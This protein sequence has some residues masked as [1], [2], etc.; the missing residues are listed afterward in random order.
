MKRLLILITLLPLFLTGCNSAPQKST[1]N[2][3]TSNPVKKNIAQDQAKEAEEITAIEKQTITLEQPE[4][5][6][7]EVRFH[8]NIAPMKLNHIEQGYSWRLL[9]S[10]EPDFEFDKNVYWYR[11]V[12]KYPFNWVSDL[13]S[14]THYFRVCLYYGE[15][16][17]DDGDCALYSNTVKAL[18]P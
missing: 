14:G 5:K 15:Y 13:P 4:I 11:T 16:D 2:I 17:Q 9:R 6:G 3:D 12:I 8:W 10:T 1:E 7:N 18:I